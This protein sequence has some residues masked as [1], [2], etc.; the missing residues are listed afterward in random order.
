MENRDFQMLVVTRLPRHVFQHLSDRRSSPRP[1]FLKN[2]FPINTTLTLIAIA[3]LVARSQSN[4]PRSPALPRP[5]K[6]ERRHCFPS[7]ED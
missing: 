4:G 6:G 5:A 2:I 1:Q 7:G 3:E